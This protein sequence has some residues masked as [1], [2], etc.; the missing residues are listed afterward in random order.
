MFGPELLWLRTILRELS[1]LKATAEKYQVLY[2]GFS[3]AMTLNCSSFVYYSWKSLFLHDILK[4]GEE[5]TSS[6]KINTDLWHKVTIP[7]F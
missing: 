6:L 3:N 4:C 2:L 5:E 1:I 7:A